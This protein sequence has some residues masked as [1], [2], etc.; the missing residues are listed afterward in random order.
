MLK[1]FRFKIYFKNH[2]YIYTH[3]YN[4]KILTFYMF[5][6]SLIVFYNGQ[7]FAPPW[8]DFLAMPLL[9]IAYKLDIDS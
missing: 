4:S 1:K 8:F 5:L 7:N 3:T 2:T 9:T 6:S